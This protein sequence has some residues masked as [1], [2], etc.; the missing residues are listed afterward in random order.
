M[1]DEVAHRAPAVRPDHRH[2]EARDPAVDEDHGGPRARGLQHQRRAAVGGG[3]QQ[4]VDAPVQ[5]CADVVVLE[6]GP[7][8][9]VADDDAVAER[10]GLLLHGAGQLGEVRVEHVADD[11]AEGPGLVG[12]QGA[13][14]GVGAVAQGRDGGEHAGARVR[15]DRGMVVEHTGHRGDGYSGLGGDVL[16]A[17]HRSTSSWN[18]LHRRLETITR[19]VRKTPRPDRDQA[20]VRRPP[21]RCPP[22][23]VRGRHPVHGE[24]PLRPRERR[25]RARDVVPRR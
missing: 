21:A 19:Q 24:A 3:D 12:A 5:E 25:G 1:G 10:A 16:D 6:V 13:G 11:Q 15:A 9:G 23:S 18:R 17:R 4:P 22:P 8:V 7:L 14:H 2:V 20:A